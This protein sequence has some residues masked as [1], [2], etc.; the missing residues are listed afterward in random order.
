M[1]FTEGQKVSYK[2][3]SVPATIISG[4]HASPGAD[5]YLIRKA[6]ENVSLVKEGELSVALSRREVVARA[7]CSVERPYGWLS[8][9][10]EGK[11]KLF[12]K[13]DAVLAALDAMPPEVAPLAV[14]DSI[15]IL[16]RGLGDAAVSAGDVLK[17]TTVGH[18]GFTTN[19]PASLF[20]HASWSFKLADEGTGWERI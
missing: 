9:S 11:C 19:N 5:R 20:V 4:P 14:G 10:I 12:R 17:V 15:R 1:T 8:L 18:S 13:A 7:I 2:G 16:K 3:M 6:D